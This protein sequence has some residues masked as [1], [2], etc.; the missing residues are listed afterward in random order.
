MPAPTNSFKAA[1][2]AGKT[3]IGLWLGLANAYA[4]EICAGA[5]FDWLLID[6]EHS[7]TDVQTMVTQLQAIEA[8]ASHPVVRAPIGETWIIKQL[9]D[10]GAQT[11]LI[12]M[13]E[14]AEQAREL[15][16]AT[17]YPPQGIR[18][19]GAALARASAF[20]RIGDYLT[21]AN[22]QI[23]LLVQVESMAGMA[24]IEEIAAVEGVDGVFIGPSDLAADMGYIGRP[25]EAAVQK[26]V[27]DGL[28]RIMA[29][30]KPAGILT[31]DPALAT[32][33]IE[34]GAS[35]VAVGTDVTLFANATTALAAKFKQRITPPPAPPQS[36]A[37]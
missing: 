13:V 10:I 20:N 22:A 1:I 12:P 28:L 25:G 3:Q 11:L 19:V 17:R 15:V 30:G 7:P 32:R 16:R 8:S 21:T 24:A 29:A 27:E 34:M 18:G 35:F 5:G 37:Y 4:A 26:I 36:T 33:Y 9:L 6:G 31:S 2:A 14:T 23:C